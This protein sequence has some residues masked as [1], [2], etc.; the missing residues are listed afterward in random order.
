MR[1]MTI[2]K[3]VTIRHWG[4]IMLVGCKVQLTDLQCDICL[5]AEVKEDRTFVA[6]IETP[7]MPELVAN[8]ISLLICRF[9]IRRWGLQGHAL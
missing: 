7:I 9:T 8:K 5:I 6:A 4:P 3:H 2:E 1:C